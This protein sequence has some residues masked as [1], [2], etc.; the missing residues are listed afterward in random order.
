ML[1]FA[2]WKYAIVAVV[3]VLALLI[4]TPNFLVRTC[5]V[6]VA[7]RDRAA[8]DE[9]GHQIHRRCAG[10]A[11]ITVKRVV[12]GWRPRRHAAVR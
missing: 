7:R 6:Q 3:M 1:E 11:G 12:R 5:A 4:A 8:V 9:A 10:H 2:R